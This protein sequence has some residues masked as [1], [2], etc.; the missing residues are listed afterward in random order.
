MKLGANTWIWVSPLT[1]ER[2]TQLAPRVR[3][4]G[5]DVIEL[6]VENLG[7]WN[8][9]HAAEVLAEH[10]LG[11]SL[12]PVA[13]YAG[14]VGVKVGIEPLVRYETSFINTVEQALEAI[15][16]LPD[17][18]GLLLDTYHANVEEKDFAGSF[19][20]GG[21]RIVHVHASANDRGAPGSDHIDW[22]GF[23]DAIRET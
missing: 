21:S 17:S 12:K 4:M 11:E 3:E 20:A 1:D 5:F 10:G 15:D 8:P 14:E 7:D 2:L 23:R 22:P 16:G 9:E 18:I 13:E 19:R 6:P